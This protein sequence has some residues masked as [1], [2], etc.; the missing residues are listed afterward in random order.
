VRDS[1][2]AFAGS[3]VQCRAPS[4][5]NGVA[6][7]ATGCDGKGACPAVQTHSC[8]AFACKG[9][10]CASECATTA[11][12]AAGF[13]CVGKDCKPQ[14]GSATCKD[15]HTVLSPDGKTTA[16]CAPYTCEVQ[17]G[18]KA[19][20]RATCTSSANCTQGTVCDTSQAGGACVAAGEGTTSEDEGGC[21]C[22]ISP[23][24]RGLPAV[25]L[26][27]IAALILRSRGRFR[28]L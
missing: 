21:G 14:E 25:L 11:D 4:C 8:G 15:A 10:A 22:R 28:P 3:G 13:V 26:A 2:N 6:V 5:S 20:C 18:G 9:E 19:Q 16:D 12:C 23:Q 7:L 1:C 24:P 27:V 17:D